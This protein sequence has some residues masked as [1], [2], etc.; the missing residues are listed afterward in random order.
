MLKNVGG[1]SYP[2]HIGIESKG[3]KQSIRVSA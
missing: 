1:G 3:I 2:P